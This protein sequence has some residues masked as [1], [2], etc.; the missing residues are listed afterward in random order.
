MLLIIAKELCKATTNCQ[1]FISIS[2]FYMCHP[3]FAQG[4]ILDLEGYYHLNNNN[5]KKAHTLRA[6]LSQY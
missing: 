4:S 6:L 3:S 5:N 1:G 2:V